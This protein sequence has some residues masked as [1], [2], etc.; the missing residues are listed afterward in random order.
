MLKTVLS[1]S[2]SLSFS[3]CCLFFFFANDKQKT[4][5]FLTFCLYIPVY[6]KKGS[7][8]METGDHVTVPL[9]DSNTNAQF[10]VRLNDSTKTYTVRMSKQIQG[11]FVYLGP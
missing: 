5:A 10:F 2:L 6:K 8:P 11:K 7:I 9:S 1:H 4:F 3:P